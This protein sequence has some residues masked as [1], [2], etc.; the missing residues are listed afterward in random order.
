M[1][2]PEVF[3]IDILLEPDA[4]MLA[5]AERNNAR[6]RAEFPGSFSL[7]EQHRPHI[8]LLQCFVAVK[9]LDAVYAAVGDV[10]LAARLARMELDAVRFGYTPGPG[11]GI[12]GIW[13]AVS[14]DLLKLQADVIA[15]TMPFMMTTATIDAFTS[16]HGN[17]SYDAAMIEYVTHFVQKGAGA[18]F[19]PHVSTGVAA[20]EYLD[21]MVGEPFE[22]FAFAPESA[23][24]YQLGPF[25]TAA[26]LLKRWEKAA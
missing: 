9:D 6:L 24:V 16:G 18:N 26:R 14:P 2:T 17:A 5:H 21:A 11:M 3:A 23:A 10:V 13:A 22:P 15:A 19:E 1:A 4:C 25:G 8:T 12:A 7:D 20:I